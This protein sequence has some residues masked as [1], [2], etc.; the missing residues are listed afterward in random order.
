MILLF[1][2]ST[3][4][5]YKKAFKHIKSLIQSDTDKDKIL[6]YINNIESDDVDNLNKLRIIIQRVA[7]TL[8][9]RYSHYHSYNAKDVTT[10]KRKDGSDIGNGTQWK[11]GDLVTRKK[12][13]SI[14]YIAI[15]E[16]HIEYAKIFVKNNKDQY[17]YLINLIDKEK[18]KSIKFLCDYFFEVV[19]WSLEHAVEKHEL[20]HPTFVYTD[21]HYRDTPEQIKTK[22]ENINDMDFDN[23]VIEISKLNKKITKQIEKSIEQN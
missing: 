7:K 11:A 2:A 6:H 9:E 21:D 20:M 15:H 4:S 3:T 8:L 5:Q 16:D 13:D 19:E 22:L 18:I 1:E 23:E 14:K 12:Y 10:R 17:L